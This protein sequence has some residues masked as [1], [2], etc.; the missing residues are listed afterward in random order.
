MPRLLYLS[1]FFSFF[2]FSGTLEAQQSDMEK[3]RLYLLDAWVDSLQ[4]AVN[5]NHYQEAHTWQR[6]LDSAM[7]K[8]IP[9]STRFGFLLES[10]GYYFNTR[11]IKDALA[12]YN[13]ARE[14]ALKMGDSSRV[15]NSS[16]GYANALSIAGESLKS[17]QINRGVLKMLRAQSNL[18]AYNGVLLNMAFSHQAISQFDS[19]L[20]KMK[21][22]TFFFD[23]TQNYQYLGVVLNN[24]GELY[25]EHL[26]EPQTALEHYRE[27]LKNYRKASFKHGMAQV[28]HN[29]SV[30]YL[31]QNKLDSAF[32]Y[33]QRSIQLRKEM[34]DKGGQAPN[35]YV[36]GEIYRE[37]GE[38][39][40]AEENYQKA[41]HL[42]QENQFLEGL[43][44]CYN[45][46]SK[47]HQAWNNPIL[48]KQNL[49]KALEVAKSLEKLP[50]LKE[51][52]KRL[53]L[54]HLGIQDTGEA[55]L[56]LQKYSR[57]NDSLNKAIS[58]KELMR[59]R[60]QYENAITQSENKA[61]REKQNLQKEVIRNQRLLLTVALVA[62][63]L[64]LLLSLFLIRLAGQR[65]RAL[66]KYQES[67]KE[68]A[69]QLDII[70][71]QKEEL[72]ETNRL[73]DQ[74][75]S[76]LSHD[77]R[78]PLTSIS[79]LLA[80]LSAEEITRDELQEMTGYLKNEIDLSLRTL[81][82]ILQ[83]TR[84][85]M[86]DQMP[87]PQ[88]IKL[89]DKLIEILDIYQANIRSKELLTN[90]HVNVLPYLI[91]NPV[92]LQ[93]MVGNL[94]SNAIKFSPS[95][96]KIWIYSGQRHGQAFL[97]IRDQGK[98]ISP[99]IIQKLESNQRRMGSEK[100][101]QGEIGTG[102][103]LR[104]VQ[105]FIQSIG[106]HLHFENHPDGGA[107]AMLFFPPS[108]IPDSSR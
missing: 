55:L 23:S 96:G 100:G 49:F 6:R 10:G 34:G 73:K 70:R 51:A 89:E 37:R 28:Y 30:N 8:E 106:G 14:L 66:E 92:Q 71:K 38:F 87:E 69:G 105:D 64:L 32:Q 63:V 81:Q 85:Q 80:T 79:G 36:L 61:L 20:S 31:A 44:H 11:Q 97:A 98:G 35:F 58:E 67:Q 22:A 50:L 27:S 95:K 74:I 107:I 72:D 1:L 25:R 12:Y 76:V 17:L 75:L 99:E 47:L 24:M 88:K 104:I 52:Y 16:S 29:M 86:E 54:F 93:S 53:Y 90:V 68:L 2:S 48:A 4:T 40:K 101:T 33:C 91:I 18:T 3:G 9:D 46:L 60:A 39:F 82:D 21:R 84:L 108:A 77:L 45:G 13:Q 42:A 7:S 103:G 43:Y 19:A 15:I 62:G 78:S 5:Q 57:Y 102:V 41:L 65:K 83:W 94:L 26:D 56:Y 59:S